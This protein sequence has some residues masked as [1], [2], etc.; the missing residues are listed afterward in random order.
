M[1]IVAFA[2]MYYR[3]REY[4]WPLCDSFNCILLIKL[5]LNTDNSKWE[6]LL[7]ISDNHFSEVFFNIHIDSIKI[8]FI[9]FID[10]KAMKTLKVIFII[11][12]KLKNDV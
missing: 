10:L 1:F 4:C 6:C 7:C 3:K 9:V 2:N 12:Q 5:N 8:L 11:I